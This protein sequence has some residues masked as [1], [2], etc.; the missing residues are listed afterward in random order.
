[1]LFQGLTLV[2]LSFTISCLGRISRESC[3]HSLLIFHQILPC[4]S[5]YTKNTTAVNK[6]QLFLPVVTRLCVVTQKSRIG[7]R[8]CTTQRYP[9]SV[10]AGHSRA[11]PL[12][13]S[14]LHN[15]SFDFCVPHHAYASVTAWLLKTKALQ[16]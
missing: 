2:I 10:M 14:S 7:W 8:S 16:W 5:W 4:S 13:T 1:M 9:R 12:K 3:V 11:R 15:H 6:Q